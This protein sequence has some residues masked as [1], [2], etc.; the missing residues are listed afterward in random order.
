VS[1]QPELMEDYYSILLRM[2]SSLALKN[3]LSGLK[4]LVNMV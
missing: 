4:H 3:A 2:H 1:S